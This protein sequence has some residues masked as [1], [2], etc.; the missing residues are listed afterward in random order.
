MQGRRRSTAELPG[1]ARACA[2]LAAGEAV[3]VP[4]PPPMAYGLVA[5]SAWK[6]N[7][8]KGRALDQNVAVSLHDQSVWRRML[9][10]IDV[11]VA[12]LKGVVALLDRRLSLLL[13]LRAD[14]PCPGWVASAVR[15]RRLG[16]FNGRWDATAA[17]W[18]RFPR[19]YGSSANRAGEAPA[20]SAR[21][22]RAALGRQC[23]VIDGDGL[24]D[25]SRA[26]AASTMVQ[27]DRRGRLSLYRSG[28][29][30]QA[31]RNRS[32]AYVRHLGDLVG[33][34]AHGGTGEAQ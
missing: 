31:W 34:P 12:T 6:I 18:E 13:P 5:T 32:E 16:A 33:L 14:R 19:L 10:S 30:D 23:V 11:P 15:D 17:V 9:P 8:V 20:G 22:A 1:L 27:L 4:N 3:V 28:A 7:A 21:D 24:G 26:P 25:P 29:H 2:A